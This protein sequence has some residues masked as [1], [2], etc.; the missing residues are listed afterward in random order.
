MHTRHDPLFL[1]V[2]CLLFLCVSWTAV[3][4]TEFPCRPSEP[5]YA[6]SALSV[7]D[8]K[9]HQLASPDG[10]KHIETSVKRV[11]TD[12]NGQQVQIKVA[13]AG[14]S[15]EAD[16]SGWGAE[17][18]WS[19][20][21]KAFFV[22]QTEGGGGIG[23]RAYVFYVE[24]T[25]LSKLDVSHIVEERSGYPASC[26]GD[27]APNVAAVA[28]LG[29]HRLLMVA[30]SVPVAPLCRCPGAFKA[31]ELELPGNKIV[32]MFTQSEAKRKFRNLLGCELRAADDK[33][34]Q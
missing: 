29:S 4:G 20:D 16:L 31:Y 26:G 14:K 15:F 1:S 7:H 30:E 5:L 22:T 2:V 33:C 8:N 13:V 11:P 6:R 18:A 34:V 32:N 12:P 19:P 10:L 17:I 9:L 23:I 28:W 25:G 27:L 24:S 3:A 21:S